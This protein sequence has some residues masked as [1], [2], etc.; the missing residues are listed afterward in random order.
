MVLLALLVLC[1]AAILPAAAAPSAADQVKAICDKTLTD[2]FQAHGVQA[3][4]IQSMDTGKVIYDHNGDMNL[5]PASN[6]KILATGA[7]LDL[8]GPDFKMTTSLYATR[9]PNDDGVIKGDLVLV[10]QGDSILKIEHLQKMVDK[11]KEM[12][13][14]KIKGNIVGDDTWFDDQRLAPGW[15][16]DDEQ[17]YDCSQ[18]SG[19]NVNENLIEVFVKPGKKAGDPAVVEL[20][21]DTKFMQI[22]NE[23]VTGAAGSGWTADCS[24]IHETN[25]IRVY[26]SVPAGSN[27]STL[28]PL[29][30][31]HPTEF[32]C[33]VFKELCE[34]SGIKVTGKAIR[35]TKPEKVILIASHDSPPLAEVIHI[36][37]KPSDNFMAEC[38]LKTLGKVVKGQGSFSAGIAVETEWL[39]NM[40]CDMNQIYIADSSG[41]SR[42]NLISAHNLVVILTHIYKGKYYDII[43]NGFPIAGVDS[44]LKDRMLGTPAVNNVKAKTGYIPRQCSLSGYCT[45]LAGEHMAVSVIQNNHMCSLEEAY[46]MQDEIFTAVSRITTRTD[47]EPGTSK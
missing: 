9:K 8:I 5:V 15:A 23:C 35:G 10:G 16:W 27:G 19:L 43:S 37:L 18:P 32:V 14:T 36:L 41:Q 12:G 6:M 42:C 7:A 11:L 22:K 47:A 3:V 28:Y 25:T 29:S 26:G 38:L 21:P 24:R 34:K 1:A 20:R 33:T 4:L 13:V 40:G 30:M 44:H 17:Y 31:D 45:T 2:P 39:K 46:V